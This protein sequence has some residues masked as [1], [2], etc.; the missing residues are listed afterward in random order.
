MDH[1]TVSYASADALATTNSEET[2]LNQKPHNHAR[3]KTN[4]DRIQKP[5]FNNKRPRFTK[6]PQNRRGG[7]AYTKQT[8]QTSLQIVPRI[9]VFPVFTS[10]LGCRDLSRLTFQVIQ[11]KDYRLALNISEDQLTYVMTIAYCNRICQ[12]AIHC[13]YAFPADASRLKQV[14][15]GIQL[16]DVLAKYIEAIGVVQLLS[17][18]TIVPFSGDYRTIFPVRSRIMIDPATVLNG[19]RRPV[20]PGAWAIDV[21]YIVAYNEATSRA[22]RSGMKFRTVNH[23]VYEGRIE[24]AVSSRREGELL[25]PVAPQTMTE[26]EAQLGATYRFR[27]YNELEQ[28]FGTDKPL[29]F[30]AFTAIPFDPRI[31]FSDACVAAFSGATVDTN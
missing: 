12:V 6:N 17:G 26:A 8:R 10:N 18:A 29:L 30:D 21:P 15:T 27:M 4:T 28:W 22:S 16:P 20:P 31:L 2:T 24:M 14:A 9:R 7:A 19:A 25:T 1:Q 3:M 23:S 11:A 5:H 13:G